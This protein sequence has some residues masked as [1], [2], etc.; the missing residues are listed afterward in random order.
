MK[1]VIEHYL[2]CGHS[3]VGAIIALGYR[4][5]RRLGPGLMSTS[6]IAESVWSAKRTAA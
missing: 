6:L 3:F 4:F 2:S 1:V 5:V